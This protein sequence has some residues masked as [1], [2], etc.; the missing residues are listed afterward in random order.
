MATRWTVV[1]G[2]TASDNGLALR[3]P[4]TLRCTWS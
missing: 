1:E 2:D 3:Y 4:R